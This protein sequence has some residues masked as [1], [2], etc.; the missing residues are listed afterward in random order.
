M[1]T[2]GTCLS[3]KWQQATRLL[4]VVG[5]LFPGAAYVSAQQTT[6]SVRGVVRD[7]Q[8]AVVPDVR[9]ELL[10]A[11]TGAALTQTSSTEGLYVFNLVPPGIYVLTTE[12]A[13]FRPAAVTDIIVEVSKVT[14]IDVQLETGGIQETVEVT[15]SRP[16]IDTSSAQVSTNIERRDIETLPSFN[17]SVLELVELAPGVD[18]NMGDTSGG[19]VLNITGVGASVNGNRSGR[20][21]FYLDGVDNTGAFRNQGLNFPNPDTVQEV[22]VATSNT[23]A[24]FGRQPGGS[25]NVV[26]KSGTNQFR[27]TGAYFFRNKSLNANTW[28]NNRNDAPRPDDDRKN[29]SVSLGGPIRRDQTFFFGSFMD[30]RDNDP[31]QQN[32][33]RFPTEA[34]ARGDFSGVPVQLLDPDSGQPLAGNQIPSRLLDPVARQLVE[35]MPRV[36]S[37]DDRYFWSFEGPSRN[38]ELLAKIDHHLGAAHT[39]QLTSFT[40]WGRQTI[41]NPGGRPSATTNIPAWG[42]QL[43]ESRQYTAALRHTWILGPRMVMESRVS[44]A[45]LDADRTTENIGR[46]LADFGAQNYPISQDGARR[47]LPHLTIENGPNGRNGFLSLF[48]QGNYQAVSSLSWIAGRHNMKFGVEVQRQNIRQYDDTERIYFEFDGRHSAGLGETPQTDQF[49]YAF[50]DFMMGRTTPA[51]SYSASGILDYDVVNWNI[52]GYVQDEWRLTPRLTLTPGL[53]YEVYLQPHERDDKQVAFRMGHQSSRFPNAPTNLAFAGDAGLEDGFFEPDRNNFAPRLGLAWDVQGDG[54]TAV[55]AGV[56][57][58]YSYNPSQ[59]F[60]WSAE[61]NPWR[62]EVFGSGGRLSDPWL[63]SQEPTYT[64]PPTPLTGENIANFPW[65]PPYT[66]TGYA[67]DFET[68]YS[69][70]WNVTVERQMFEGV[71]VTAGYVGN[72]GHRFTQLLPI[73]FAEYREGADDTTA[74]INERRPIP[75]FANVMEISSTAR[76]WYD[77]L[78][79]SSTLRGGGATA[80]VSYVLAKGYDTA[81]ADPTGQGNQQAANPLDIAGERGE[82][83]RRHTFRAF[84]AW[85]VPVFRNRDTLASTLLG[86]WQISGSVR[87]RS[88]APRNITLGTDWN[89]DGV[90]GDRPDLVGDIQYPRTELDDGRYQWFDPA[91]FM[92]P[93]GG[94]NHNVFGTLPRNAIFGPGDWNVDAALLKQFRFAGG[95][96]FELRFEA[97][98]LF[99][100]PNLGNPEDD[101]SDADF[102]QILTRTGNRRVQLGIKAYF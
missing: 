56:G 2:V 33:T 11:E 30:F 101:F 48:N 10:N 81:G 7:A 95:R 83:Q 69:L 84:F 65:T 99:N 78:Q 58:Y 45:R 76:L 18:F 87:A 52:F 82:N 15:A 71:S 61:N 23:S 50:A 8:G 20:N 38:D 57:W 55:R 19:Q 16:R 37:Y 85:D 92:L 49:A 64:S 44:V 53:R 25:F 5:L 31:G 91:A 39:L 88:G 51:V 73:N 68:P 43:N 41:P 59:F 29:T 79:F 9:L 96:R 63:T 1:I 22:Q 60:I 21:G 102:G 100:H 80:R 42:P 67:E 72:R 46:N 47:Y 12:M 3:T 62:P 93:G 27:G 86:G 34:M 35:L 74:S 77:A 66:A 75:D 90:P 14:T 6:G 94:T 40:T 13:G 70:Q 89:F 98:N 36:E 26:T 54:R 97:Y 4:L 24:E 32:N 28:A 17:R